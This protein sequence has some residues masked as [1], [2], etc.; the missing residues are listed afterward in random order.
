M[1]RTALSLPI[2]VLL[3]VAGVRS[4]DPQEAPTFSVSVNLVKVPI[5]I[6]DPKGASVLDVRRQDFVLFEDGAQQQIRSFGIDRNPV[7]VVLLV[8]T[9]A[10]VEAEEKQI[11]EA[12]ESFAEALGGDDRISI[13]TFDDD[14][15]LLQN[16]TSGP[17]QIR[18]ALRKIKPGLRTAL[19]DAMYA[20]AHDQ[21]DGV[22][23]RKA[24]ILLTDCLNNQSRVSFL[25]ASLAIVQSQASLYVVSKTVIVRKAARLQRRV[26]MLQDIYKHLF[27][28][29][30][31][32]VEEFFQKREAEMIDLAEKTGGRCF[33]PSDYGEIRGVYDEVARELKSQLFMT[34]ISNQT[35]PPNSYHRIAVDYLQPSSRLIYR[36]GYFYEP[37]PLRRRLLP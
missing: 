37:R 3:A 22:D 9:S 16:W 5:T 7:S 6:L 14:V 33:F 19:Y 20:A 36:K 23:G 8:D 28:T 11:K 27:G 25:D 31:D 4:Q 29:D 12:A 32:Y 34:Y 24:I 17:R 18:K 1:S 21:L 30:S 35:K 2:V 15:A 26:V 13:I 10:T